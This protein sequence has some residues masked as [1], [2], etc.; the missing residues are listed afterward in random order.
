M[1]K[2]MFAAFTTKSIMQRTIQHLSGLDGWKDSIMTPKCYIN[3]SRTIGQCSWESPDDVQGFLATGIP[4]Y[5]PQFPAIKFRGQFLM[6]STPCLSH[7]CDLSKP[8]YTCP[9]LGNLR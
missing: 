5:I 9:S 3:P 7:P 2:T 4:R 1:E 6:C 8:S